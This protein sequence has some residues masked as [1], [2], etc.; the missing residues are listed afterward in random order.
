[1]SRRYQRGRAYARAEMAGRA[2][3][4]RERDRPG[5]PAKTEASPSAARRKLDPA[6]A[7]RGRLEIGVGAALIVGAIG[8]AASLAPTQPPGAAAWLVGFGLAL[9]GA[10]SIAVGGARLDRRADRVATLARRRWLYGGLAVGFGLFYAFCMWKVIPNRLP[11]GMLH[12]ATIPVFTL[13]MAAGT[14]A[15]RRLGWWVGVV[16]GSLV[17]L[18]TI[19]LVARILASAAFLA[20][21]YGAFGQAAAT[22]AL[23]CVALI[24]ELVAL[25]PI[26]QVKFLMSRA[27][28][29]AHGV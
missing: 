17:L 24:V 21:V 10:L 8:Y 15:G 11:S 6:M 29:R 19:A 18:S 14:L 20:G 12:L 4:P 7:R 23:V 16:G 22:F 2:K 27:G 9:L 26:C 25:L 28:R 3:R 13:M 5:K 1:M